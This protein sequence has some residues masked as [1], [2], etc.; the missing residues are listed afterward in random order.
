[1]VFGGERC[2]GPG[3]YRAIAFFGLFPKGISKVDFALTVHW[4]CLHLLLLPLV[5]V[6]LLIHSTQL[7]VVEK[8]PFRILYFAYSS[9]E[10]RG[11]AEATDG[12]I[13]TIP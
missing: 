9:E 5:L 2:P 6:V 11:L 12:V 8:E 7:Q 4:R 13:T 3:I 10:V 1:M